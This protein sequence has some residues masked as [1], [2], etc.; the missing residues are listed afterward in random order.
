MYTI[1]LKLQ[2]LQSIHFVLSI[3][4]EATAAEARL[5]DR[6][7]L[8]F[9]SKCLKT[10]GRLQGLKEA[11]LEGFDFHEAFQ[12]PGYIAS[13]EQ[14]MLQPRSQNWTALS[15]T[16]LVRSTEYADHSYRCRLLQ[17]LHRLGHLKFQQ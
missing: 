10:L 8:S 14:R 4:G 16:S 1:L 11:K 3:E 2:S 17:R 15:K 9:E 7:M 13:V 12:D 6:F 5:S